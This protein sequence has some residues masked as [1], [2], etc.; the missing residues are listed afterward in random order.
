MTVNSP[1]LTQRAVLQAAIETTYRDEATLGN[2][3]GILV[4]DPSY[5]VDMTFLERN[6]ARNDLSPLAGIAGRKLAMVK[7][8]T[9]V[10]GNN[11]QQA[12]TLISAPIITRLFRG[13]GY[14]LTAHNAKNA[15]I[16]QVGDVANNPSWVTGGTLTNTDVIVYYV[17]VTTGGASGTAQLTVTSDTSGEGSAAA[18]V[19]TATPFSLGTKGLTITPT[20]TGNLRVGDQWVVYLFPNGLKLTPVSTGFE[21][22]TMKLSLDGMVHTLLGCFGT[23]TMNAENGQYAKIEWTFT[24]TF[25]PA[26]DA[27]LPSP[28]YETSIPHMV[29]FARLHIDGYRAIVAALDF[30]QAND[31]QMRPDVSS[32]EGYIGTRI[33]GRKPT[34]GI[35]PEAELVADQDFWGK[36]GSGVR[37]PF[38]MRIGV[39]AGNTVWFL[40]SNTQYSGLTYQDRNG[41][42]AYDAGLAFSRSTGDDECLW[43]FC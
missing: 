30:D 31:I 19:T 16:K 9:E 20:F 13:C 26:V 28:V 37:M 39:S 24:G 41:I 36:M 6:F 23:F 1:L 17:K 3:D 34:G 14:A 7:F 15:M 32:A 12:G 8:T 33:V 2:S 5:E 40:A 43:Y 18:S 21:S 27:A 35:D 38:Q 42:R 4:E 29:E 11:L 22:L 10:R 25:E